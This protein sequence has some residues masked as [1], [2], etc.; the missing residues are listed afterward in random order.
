MKRNLHSHT[1]FCDG[2]NSMEEILVE[3]MKAG[4]TSWGFT[5]HAPISIDSPCNMMENKVELYLKEVE[6]LKNKYPEIEIL[7]GRFG[8]YIA[9]KGKNYKMP[10]TVE[11]PAEL[12]LEEVLEIVKQQD[13][14]PAPTRG[15]RA[16]RKK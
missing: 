16:T 14:K 15:R 5:P 13:E 1:Q 8:V 6:R 7:N 2:R 9:A 3:A 10:K 11:N 12:T 4:F